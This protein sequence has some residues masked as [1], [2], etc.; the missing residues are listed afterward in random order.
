MTT[1][2]ELAPQMGPPYRGDAAV[3]EGLELACGTGAV[4]CQAARALQ[5]M[6]HA[7][8]VEFW[9]GDMLCLAG[10]LDAFA[11]LTVKE[12]DLPP[13]FVPYVPFPGRGEVTGQPAGAFKSS[14]PRP[15][16]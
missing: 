12:G 5:A 7:G 1:R 2:V 3:F 14:A 16:L 6:G 8:R 11:K 15:F 4:C 10:P 9:R 13:R